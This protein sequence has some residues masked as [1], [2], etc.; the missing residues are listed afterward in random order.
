MREIE[1]LL[2]HREPFLFVDEIISASKEEIVGV[3][4]FNNTDYLLQGSFPD[5]DFVP[6][7]ILIESMAQCGGAGVRKLGIIKHLF[8]LATIEGAN[9]F[10]KVA[11]KKTVTMVIK[12]VKLSE[13]MIKQSGVAYVDDEPV[14]EA[15][16]ICFRI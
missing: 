10:N 16:W 12:N 11:F 1:T 4:I 9:F 3:K 2:P 13:R 5:S 7:I 14:A 15:T 6:G 8:A